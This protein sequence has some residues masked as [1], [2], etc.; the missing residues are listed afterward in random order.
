MSKAF[1]NP[2]QKKAPSIDMEDPSTIPTFQDFGKHVFT[3][4]LADKY[5]KKY[6]ASIE[7][8]NDPSWVANH[9][10][11]VAAAVLEW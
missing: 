8:L 2:L 6:G 3:G 10:D 1:R 7:I 9:A 11:A 5:L 4:K